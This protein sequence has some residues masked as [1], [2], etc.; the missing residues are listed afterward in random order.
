M[1]EEQRFQ[2]A[3]FNDFYPSQLCQVLI[4]FCNLVVTSY[5]FQVLS[6][7]KIIQVDESVLQQ[8]PHEI[9]SQ[10]VGSYT[11]NTHRKSSNDIDVQDEPATANE[12]PSLPDINAVSEGEP[13]HIKN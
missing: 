8:L 5:S 4:F 12:L 1:N 9:R 3:Q 7:T 13:G 10:V 2:S 11:K 6:I